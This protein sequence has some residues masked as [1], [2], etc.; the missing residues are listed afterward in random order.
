MELL[1]T[2]RELRELLGLE[3]TWIF[4]LV[5]ALFAGICAYLVDKADRKKAASE[6]PPK[7]EEPLIPPGST[8]ALMPLPFFPVPPPITDEQYRN[9]L[10]EITTRPSPPLRIDI[11]G[12]SFHPHSPEKSVAI[13][14]VLPGASELS[15][16]FRFRIHILNTSRDRRVSLQFSSFEI[17]TG[18]ATNGI[19]AEGITKNLGPEEDTEGIITIQIMESMYRH[20]T[21]RRHLKLLRIKELV[22]GRDLTVTIPTGDAERFIRESSA[23]ESSGKSSK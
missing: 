13:Q 17:V 20:F 2:L 21:T 12:F 15:S 8:V 22:S 16:P 1:K 3:N 9:I 4:V 10:E 18:F 23:K 5:V 19:D 7:A 6:Q 14:K 11:D